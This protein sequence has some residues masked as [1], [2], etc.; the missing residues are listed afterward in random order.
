ML[1]PFKMDKKHEKLSNFEVLDSNKCYSPPNTFSFLNQKVE[2]EDNIDWNYIDNGLLWNYNL[3]YLDFLSNKE[4]L[5]K[6]S[7]IISF[8]KKYNS[9]KAGKDPYPTSLRIIN[10]IKY[11]VSENNYSD[12][13]IDLIYLDTRNLLKWREYHLL[14]NHLLENAMA[15]YFAAHIF[16]SHELRLL[17]T[18]LL[19]K[20]LNEQIL[21]D[22]AHFELSPMYHQ[23]ILKRLLECISISNKNRQKWNEEINKIL[24]KKA[25][26][27]AN[28]LYTVSDNFKYFIRIN[29]SVEGI[30]PR[31]LELR[32][33]CH[34]LNIPFN[35]INTLKESKIR[36]I[37]GLNYFLLFD[38][39][40]IISKY[41]A[42]HS[43]AD[44]LNFLLF[45]RETPLIVDPGISTYERG[46]QRLSERST[47]QHNTISLDDLNTD[48]VWGS[49]R[50]GFKSKTEFLIDS[51]NHIEVSNDG[52]QRIGVNIFRKII[53]DGAL[54]QIFDKI[55]CRNNKEATLNLHF[56]PKRKI[57]L[58]STKKVLIENL[59]EITFVGFKKIE[60]C[61]YYYAEGFNNKVEADKLIIT[62]E[63]EILTQIRIN[64]KTV[65]N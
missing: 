52:Y 10:L 35:K 37:K 44:S 50:V 5:N 58:V 8:Y 39:S 3:N 60:K 4:T 29:D 18:Q 40:N 9:L 62:F 41:Q 38:G 46:K 19:K 51:P 59:A 45:I 22:G 33:Y 55:E 48:D 11:I 28:W 36:I 1:I 64:E 25:E 6:Q 63:K 31:L 17:S 30:A 14:G 65:V 43:H 34:L 47:K 7:I 12:E 21:S 16:S 32:E 56:H 57:D 20:E 23:I 15:L 49:F 2:F 61:Q 42:G 26:L 53:V 13:L 24:I 54:I 27:M